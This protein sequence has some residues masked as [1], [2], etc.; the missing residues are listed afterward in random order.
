[1]KKIATLFFLFFIIL[2]YITKD[3]TQPVFEEITSPSTD[4][5][6]HIYEIKIKDG[7][8]TTKNFE[9][10]FDKIKV[11]RITPLLNP[12]Y[13]ERLKNEVGTYSFTENSIENNILTFTKKYDSILKNHGFLKD[14]TQMYIEGIKI[15]K[16]EIF[17]TKGTLQK[18]Q[19]IIQTVRT[20]D[21]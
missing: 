9:Q 20:K 6:S 21:N 18:L 1:M 2:T 19:S 17:G 11:L 3:N 12:I 16:V 8:I 10:Y 4:S 7:T 15:S 5:Q 14:S 13:E